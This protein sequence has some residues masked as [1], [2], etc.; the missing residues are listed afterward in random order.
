MICQSRRVS[1]EVQRVRTAIVAVIFLAAN[2]SVAAQEPITLKGHGGWVGAVAFA[3]DNRRLAI[4]TSDGRVCIW[5]VVDGKKLAT[6]Q[7]HEDAVA[8]LTFSGDGKVVVSGGHD[9]VAIVQEIQ[10]DLKAGPKHTLPGHGGAVLSLVISATPGKRFF[11]GSMDGSIREF[12]LDMNRALKVIKGHTSWVNGLA[13]DRQSTML[14]SAS[15]D[16]SVQVRRLKDA[17]VIQTFRVKE[18]EIRSVAFSPDGKLAAAGIR[19]GG[20]RVWNLNDQ[21]EVASL[22]AHNG[23]TWAVAFTPDGKTLASGGGDW[24]KPGEVRLWNVDTWKERAKLQHSGEVL[25][26]SISADGNY[27]AAGSWDRTVKVWKVP[28]MP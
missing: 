14:A 7:K 11:T 3:P 21:K 24:N 12:D 25:C 6:L 4:G 18:G 10:A 15:S 22:K 19:Y 2:R 28:R 8:A 27:L 9:R 20:V 26:L 23:E 16:N 1:E 5:D 17:E 13:T